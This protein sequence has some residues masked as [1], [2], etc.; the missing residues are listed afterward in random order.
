MKVLYI[1]IWWFGYIKID[2]MNAGFSWSSG[3]EG[4]L[5]ISHEVNSEA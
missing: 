1:K 5:G 4:L 2:V 3:G